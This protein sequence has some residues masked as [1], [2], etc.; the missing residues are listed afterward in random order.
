MAIAT[1]AVAALMA[2]APCLTW[3]QQHQQQ[4]FRPGTAMATL[5]AAAPHPARRWQHSQ[6]R[7]C[8]QHGGS[9]ISGCAKPGTVTA[10]VMAHQ[11]E[12]CC[13]IK[14]RAWRISRVSVKMGSL[15]LLPPPCC[16][17]RLLLL[18]S[19]ASSAGSLV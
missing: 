18:Q 5:A 9:N 1:L 19:P 6:Q 3:W 11:A 2:E 13:S 14:L 10:S 7:L 8:A 17:F 15:W 12:S 4:C 16:P